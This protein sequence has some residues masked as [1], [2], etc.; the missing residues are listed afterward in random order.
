[1][2]AITQENKLGQRYIEASDFLKNGVPASILAT[3]VRTFELF[4]FNLEVAKSTFREKVIVTIGYAICRG[5]G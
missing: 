3:I 5:L 1:M 4:A 2:T